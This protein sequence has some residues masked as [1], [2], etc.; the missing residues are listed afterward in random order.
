MPL[1]SSGDE[2]G[3]WNAIVQPTLR[4]L[5]HPFDGCDVVTRA[6]PDLLVIT[7]P[8]LPGESDGPRTRAPLAPPSLN[9]S[10]KGSTS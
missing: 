8:P 7:I 9:P 10:F 1:R 4:S 6:R 2:P 5:C 3:G